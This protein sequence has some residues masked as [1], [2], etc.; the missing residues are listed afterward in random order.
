MDVQKCGDD[1]T[2]SVIAVDSLEIKPPLNIGRR[3][4]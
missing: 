3:E 4:R 2:D 1:G